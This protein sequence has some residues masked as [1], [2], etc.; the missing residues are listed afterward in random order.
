MA[1]TA[2]LIAAM[3]ATVGFGVDAFVVLPSFT[4]VSVYELYIY[5]GRGVEK[6]H[7]ERKT[8]S[9]SEREENE[10]VV[11]HRTCGEAR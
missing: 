7:M 11:I 8:G 9:R 2:L 6:F 5:I 3:T 1:A 4:M 10:A